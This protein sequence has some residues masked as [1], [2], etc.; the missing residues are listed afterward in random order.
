MYDV[1]TRSTLFGL[2]NADKVINTNDKGRIF[3]DIGQFTNA[4]TAISRLD[5]AVGKGAQS[6][7]NAM[8]HVAKESKILTAAGKGATWASQNVNPLL[9]G[10]AGYRVLISDDK[11]S[12]LKREILGMSSMFGVEALV[13][14][15]FKSHTFQ[16]AKRNI[17]KTPTQ[18]AIC[19]IIEGLLFVGASIAAS[20]TGYKIGKKLYPDKIKPNQNYK[21]TINEQPQIEQNTNTND[22]SEIDESEYFLTKNSKAL[23]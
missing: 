12:S 23:A 7:I 13:K 15:V 4:A 9:I 14:E 2:R 21:F 17:C 11:E 1:L 3:A 18:K 16:N 19:S 20:T 6:A 8:N 10:A 22:T 5:N